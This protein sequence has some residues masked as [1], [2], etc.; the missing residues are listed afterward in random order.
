MF[1]SILLDLIPP[2]LGEFTFGTPAA[3]VGN[4]ATRG[5]L[6]ASQ[7]ATLHVHSK[8]LL[9]VILTDNCLIA[10]RHATNAMIRRWNISLQKKRNL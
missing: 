8:V 3:V 5:P 4:E 10:S 7:T 1:S 2:L 6:S 9:L